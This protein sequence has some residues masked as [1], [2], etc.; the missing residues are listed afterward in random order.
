MNRT[1][2]VIP[3]DSTEDY[4]ASNLVHRGELHYT[5]AWLK[6]IFEDIYEAARETFAKGGEVDIP[7]A[8][9]EPDE[10]IDKMTGL[11]YDLQ[12][13]GA[14]VDEEDRKRFSIGSEVLKKAVKLAGKTSRFT[15]QV[16][17]TRDRD[18]EL[19]SRDFTRL[20]DGLEINKK[21][22]NEAMNRIRDRLREN[23]GVLG[24]P[25][26]KM[27][28][29]LEETLYHVAFTK[30]VPSIMETGI[31]PRG[32]KKAHWNVGRSQSPKKLYAFTNKDRAK[33]WAASMRS[34]WGV[35][36]KDVSIISF[37][38][39][40]GSFSRDLQA[41]A[42][43][44][45]TAVQADKNIIPENII[46]SEVA[47][48]APLVK[49]KVADDVVGDTIEIPIR[50][51]PKTKDVVPRYW[52]HSI[53]GREFG[54]KGEILPYSHREFDILLPDYFPAQL[55]RYKSGEIYDNPYLKTKTP[56]TKA[57]YLAQDPSYIP[58]AI[59]ID[60]SKLDPDLMRLTG[61]AEGHAI[62]AGEIP[63]SAQ[64]DISKTDYATGGKVLGGLKRTRRAKG[65]YI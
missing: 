40:S 26:Q 38:D 27:D 9:T 6:E 3:L 11:P 49:G 55:R 10:R 23:D 17:L 50:V 47:G 21:E 12:A 30:D 46:G 13:G 28:S 15:K 24:E 20:S 57:I 51:N 8:P 44:Q 58:D 35:G 19:L 7:Q 32:G 65:G 52:Y 5:P 37:K 54:K 25:P 36:E 14:F 22:M 53:G 33:G 56:P 39:S 64:V 1:E 34:E 62:Y 2:L 41:P 59:K 18:L 4:S 45:S 29:E 61:Q 43:Y 63:K 31:V 16:S 42:S 48:K 60:A